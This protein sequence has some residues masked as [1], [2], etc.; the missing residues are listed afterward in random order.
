MR[1]LSTC[2]PTRSCTP[3][4][5]EQIRQVNIVKRRTSTAPVCTTK[6]LL[7]LR[8][9]RKLLPLGTLAKLVISSP[10]FG[11]FQCG[12]GLT[13]FFELRLGIRFFGHIGVKLACQLA[14]SLFDLI[15]ISIARHTQHSIIVFVFHGDNALGIK[16][17]SL[18]LLC[19]LVCRIKRQPIQIPAHI[20]T[21]CHL[22][23]VNQIKM[24]FTLKR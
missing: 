2:L 15:Q 20:S 13:R 9:W 18:K 12:I 23:A 21:I 8:R 4:G 11:I 17:V 14:V 1:P 22:H 5:C 10:L 7:P 16:T 3:H 19:Q 24:A 6:I